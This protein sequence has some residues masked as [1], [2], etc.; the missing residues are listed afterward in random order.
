MLVGCY[1][2]HG[3][4]QLEVSR[5]LRYI[6]DITN[7]VCGIH[8]LLTCALK[9]ATFAIIIIIVIMIADVSLPFSVFARRECCVLNA[10]SVT[11]Q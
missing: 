1:R 10:T 5:G 6:V 4:G 2:D 11:G 8:L 9:T 3:E 7:T